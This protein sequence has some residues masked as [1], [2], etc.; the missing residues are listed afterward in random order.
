MKA[1]SSLL[2]FT[3]ALGGSRRLSTHNLAG[4]LSEFKGSVLSV[5]HYLESV[6]VT[7]TSTLLPQL[8]LLGSGSCS[9]LFVK[10]V[11]FSGF[12]KNQS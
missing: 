2:A 9:P 3:L 11:L 4:D 12:P 7:Q 5:D 6:K 1:I 8:E 10:L